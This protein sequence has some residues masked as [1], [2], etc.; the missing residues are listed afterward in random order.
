[1]KLS[2]FR[3]LF[4]AVILCWKMSLAETAPPMPPPPPPSP[5][6][7]EGLFSFRD[8]IDTDGSDYFRGGC[9]LKFQADWANSCT[10]SWG[11][12]GADY[13][14][15]NLHL[16]ELYAI[17]GYPHFLRCFEATC[18]DDYSSSRVNCAVQCGSKAF[19]QGK[20]DGDTFRVNSCG[21]FTPAKCWCKQ[22]DNFCDLNSPCRT[23]SIEY[24]V[25]QFVGNTCK[26]AN[27]FRDCA[28]ESNKCVPIGAQSEFETR[29][30]EFGPCQV[31][32]G[33]CV[34]VGGS[35]ALSCR[36]DVWR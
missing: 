26:L 11:Y 31:I 18:C 8:Y 9:L 19:D 5:P 6:P 20:C 29:I 32:N 24:S 35:E 12:A 25:C 13:C 4:F 15:D 2:N 21:T 23:H 34:N 3:V 16:K 10:N 30:H 28:C 17:E 7:D 33:L 36:N 27:Y 22:N 1:M 14:E